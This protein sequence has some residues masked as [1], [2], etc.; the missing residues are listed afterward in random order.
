MPLVIA[1]QVYPFRY[2]QDYFDREIRPHLG[3][4]TCGSSTRRCSSR[5]LNLL[6]H[7]RA[8]LLTSTAEETSS[9][10]AMEAMAC[11]TPVV[12]FRREHFRRSLPMADRIRGGS[13]RGDGGGDWAVVEYRPGACRARVEKLFTARRMA[14]EYEELYRVVLAT[15]SRQQRRG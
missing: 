6:R 4:P 1:G 5:K 8:L 12:A 9:L 11:G 2:H 10:V 14:Q 13:R 7:A 3:E 15:S